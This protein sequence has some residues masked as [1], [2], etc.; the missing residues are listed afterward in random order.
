MDYNLRKEHEDDTNG[1]AKVPF[2]SEGPQNLGDASFD[3][4]DQKHNFDP[5]ALEDDMKELY[6]GQV[7]KVGNNNISYELVH[8]AKS[9]Q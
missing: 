2:D 7:H 1:D 6:I 9:Q 5:M 3:L 8:S 4:E